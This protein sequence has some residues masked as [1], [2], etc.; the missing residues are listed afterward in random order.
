M[1]YIKIVPRT[2]P[3]LWWTFPLLFLRRRIWVDLYR[4]QG[5]DMRPAGRTQL[6]I[7]KLCRIAGAAAVKLAD[8][9]QRYFRICSCSNMHL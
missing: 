1:L 3:R 6:P 2:E 9:Q 5:G 8:R 4:R 7:G